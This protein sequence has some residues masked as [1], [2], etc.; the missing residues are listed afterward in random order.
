M[1]SRFPIAGSN[2]ELARIR[3]MPLRALPAEDI[4]ALVD[5][6]VEPYPASP[7]LRRVV[8]ERAEGNP[9]FVEELVRALR[10]RGDLA[11]EHGVQDLRSGAEHIIPPT[12]SA[13]LAS[14]IDGLP[15]SA[16]ELLVDAAT[17]GKEFPLAHLRAMTVSER[18][19]D[20]LALVERRGFVDRKAEGPAATLAFRHVLTQEVAYGALLQ[21][22]R[23]ARRR[24]AAET[25]ERLYRG[26]TE[27]VCD[28][29]GHH[30]AQSDQRARAVPYLLAAADGAA[31]VGANRAAIWHLETAL[32][33]MKEHP[34]AAPTEQQDALRLKLAGLYF[35][36]GER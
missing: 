15:A 18:F 11:L 7:R 31:A 36:V 25:L 28:Q 22:E 16:R 13:L 20:D 32:D 29:L 27:E 30:W 23:Q 19:E 12:I 33:L 9:F 24:R 26:R 34:E 1:T 21:P 3:E 17:L 8:E 10:E 35:V 4:H 14:R 2:L 6:Q 5:A